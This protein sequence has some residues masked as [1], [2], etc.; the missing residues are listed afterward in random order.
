V[1]DVSATTSYDIPRA[2]LLA[3]KRAAIVMGKTAPG[4]HLSWP[5]LA[6]I[7]QVE[8]D[9]GRYGG[10]RV[11]ADGSTVP[12][13]VGVPLDGKGGVARI[14]DTDGGRWDADTTWDRAV[15][16][17][18]F[19]PSTWAVVGVDA[20]DDGVRNP[21]DFDDAALAAGVYLCA[22]HRDLATPGGA[23][24]AIYSY[25]H[26]DAYVAVVLRLARA[27]AKG[28]VAVVPNA[29]PPIPSGDD[30][31]GGRRH[32]PG[33]DAGG[34]RPRH[35]GIGTAPTGPT[36]SPD[37]TPTPTPEPETTALTGFLAPCDKDPTGWCVG[38]AQLDFGAE[39][40]LS[41]A[42][43]DYDGDQT[44]EPVSDELAGLA[45]TRVRVLVDADDVVVAIQGLPYEVIAAP[46][47]TEPTPTEPTP[48]DPTPTG[49][50]S[51][52]PTSTGPTATEP[53]STE[54]T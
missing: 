29:G 32:R 27:Y 13:I 54:P 39:A 20:D 30:A 43:E 48:T 12:P 38:D 10:A 23:R 19:I 8:S 24:Q 3:Y 28:D 42:Q 36:P 14:A 52:G 22:N 1:A 51:T 21:H 7:G 16:P 35:S 11:L 31:D 17:M 26:S 6:A 15:G 5:I 34:H 4:C 45:G 53:T 46:T 41:Q 25:N 37:P 18:Q 50:T 47:P 9:Q 44:A 2:A 49:P 33:G 40:D